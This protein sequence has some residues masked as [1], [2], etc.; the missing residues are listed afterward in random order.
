MSDADP[1]LELV[2][3]RCLETLVAGEAPA[4]ADVVPL[5]RRWMPFSFKWWFCIPLIIV[6]LVSAIALEVALI[7]TREKGQSITYVDKYE[8]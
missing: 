3:T 4:S 7:Y 2:L 1:G 5:R 8:Y 6:T